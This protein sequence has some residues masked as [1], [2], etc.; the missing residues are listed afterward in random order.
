MRNITTTIIL[1]FL[2]LS[3]KS[4]DKNNEKKVIQSNPATVEI[5][6]GDSLIIGIW[7]DDNKN[8]F[9]ASLVFLKTKICYLLTDSN[10]IECKYKIKNDSLIVYEKNGK[11]S[12]SR[13]EKLTGDTLKLDTNG[14]KQTFIKNQIT[15]CD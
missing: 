12:I 8:A 1:I 3:C 9:H 4:T 13:I 5:T 15:N 10:A 11:K 6:N 7:W 2:F 14:K